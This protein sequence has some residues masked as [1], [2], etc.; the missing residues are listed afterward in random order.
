MQELAPDVEHFSGIVPALP[1]AEIES[2]LS[3]LNEEN[4][5]H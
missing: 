5:R 2:L 4:A 3:L 1:V